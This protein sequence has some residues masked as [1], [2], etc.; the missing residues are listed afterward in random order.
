MPCRA[1]RGATLHARH[2]V[3]REGALRR[4]LS[5]YAKVAIFIYSP[6]TTTLVGR[7]ILG[8]AVWLFFLTVIREL[9]GGD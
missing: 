7:V 8:V 2:A 9:W 3:V 5:L 6:P 4:G 1:I